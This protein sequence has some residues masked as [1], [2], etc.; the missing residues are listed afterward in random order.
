MRK[1]LA[2][3]MAVGVCLSIAALISCSVAVIPGSGGGGAVAFTIAGRTFV[4][5]FAEIG[6]IQVV[7]GETETVTTGRGSVFSRAPSDTP[8]SATMQLSSDNVGTFRRATAKTIV[9]SQALPL[10]GTATIRF[11]VAPGS[12]T[13]PCGEGVPLAE[14]D[15]AFTAG[16]T[17]VLDEIFELSDA[18]L[19]II[20]TNDVAF[21]IQ[22]TADFDGD[23]IIGDIEISF[24]GGDG[25]GGTGDAGT[26]EFNPWNVDTAENIHIL[27]PGEG[28]DASNRLTPGAN[29]VVTV[30]NLEIGDTVT[31][32]AGRNGTVLDTTTCPAVSGTNY[33]AVATW[34]GETIM[35]TASSDDGDGGT[36]PPG[37][38]L[39]VPID[40]P[41]GVAVAV[42]AGDVYNGIDYAIVGVLGA[43][44]PDAPTSADP[45]TVA[46]D[47]ASLG[48]A[49][50]ETMYMAVHSAWVPDLGNGVTLATLSCDYAEG[51]APTTMAFTLGSTTAEWSYLRPEHVS[52]LGGVAHDSVTVL[53][54]FSTTIGSASEYLGWVYDQSLSMDSSRTLTS[55]TLTAAS[56]GTFPSR[57]LAAEPTWAGTAIVGLTLVGPAGAPSG[58][59]GDDECVDTTDCGAGEICSN[60]TCVTDDECV[61]AADCGPGEICSNG[62]CVTDDGGGVG[63]TTQVTFD[64]GNELDSQWD[65]ASETI[66]FQTDRAPAGTSI[67]NIGAVQADGTGEGNIA[68]GPNSGFGV[69]GPMS[70]VGSTGLLMVNERV[71]FHEYM[72]FDTSQALFT[73]TV[74]DGDDEAFTR[75]LLIPGGGGGDF[76]T[77]SRD[78]STVLW[79]YS[80]RGGAGTALL[81]TAPFSTLAG[82][83]ADAA[84][85]LLFEDAD[86][87]VHT[88]KNGAAL[89][90]DA[91]QVVISLPSGDGFDLF[92]YD[93]SSPP[94]FVRQLT[95]TGASAG[96]NNGVP[97]VSPDATQVAFARTVPGEDT[98]LYLV[99]LSGTG[100]T[101]LT[102]TDRSESEPSWSPGGDRI[103]F[104]RADDDGWN[105][106]VLTLGD[107]EPV[108]ECTSDANCA[109]GETCV[110]G[111]CVPVT[112]G[113]TSSLE[114]DP[115]EKCVDGDCVPVTPECTSSLDCEPDETCVDGTC[116]PGGDEDGFTPATI[117][118]G[119][120]EHLILGPEADPNLSLQTPEGY[121]PGPFGTKSFALSGDGTKVWVA[122]YDQ[123]P[124]VEGD[125]QTQLWSVNT[126]GTGGVR[127]SLPAEDLRSGMHVTTNIDGSV[128]VA[129]NPQTTT[130]YRATPGTGVS[131]L[132]N[133][134]GI[135]DARGAMRISD[136]ASQLIYVNFSLSNIAVAD[137]SGG[138]PTPQVV[139]T[140]ASLVTNGLGGSATIFELDITSSA[141]QWMVGTRTFDSDVNRNRWP[142]FIGNGLSGPTISMVTTER[143]DLAFSRFNMTDDGQTIA[144]CRATEHNGLIGRC[145]IQSIG[146]AARTEIVDEV[147]N[148]GNLSL[149]DDGSKAYMSTGVGHGGGQGFIYGV[150]TG[151]R[152]TGGSQWFADSASPDFT[153][154]EWSDDGRLLMAAVT[155][156]IYVLHDGSVPA[157]FP[158]IDRILYR[159][160]DEDCSMTVRVEVNAP[161]G[162]ERIFTLPFYQGLAASRGVIPGAENPLFRDRS[163]GG[164]NKSTI[165]T[166]TETG[167]WERQIFLT[168]DVGDCASSLLSSDFSIRIVLV[169]DTTTRTVF[170]DFSPVPGGGGGPDCSSNGICNAECGDTDPDCAV[171]IADGVCTAGC[172][173]IDPDCAEVCVADGFCNAN[174]SDLDPDP[175]CSS[176][177]T[178]EPKCTVSSSFGSGDEGWLILGDAQGGRG[179][180]NIV[181]SGG[182][183]GGY[184]SADDDAQ[185]GVWF[186][187]APVAYRGNFSGALGKTLTF[188]LKQSS[189][190]SQFDWLDVSLTG[191]GLTIVVDAGSN[192]GL[193]WTAYSIVL[194]TSAGWTLNALGGTAATQADILT[195]FTNLSDMRSRGEYVDGVD[196]GGLDNVVLNSD[197]AGG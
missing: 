66:A 31:I 30:S 93:V 90:P 36:V 139:T 6:R 175:D 164:V 79:R 131:E 151:E 156:G 189:L 122:L 188:D 168:N 14:Y 157:G 35:C 45:S 134:S 13:D 89:T 27:M 186:F 106:Y 88:L 50:V 180:P 148:L 169:E 133:Y 177:P 25:G 130:F 150:A 80:T 34:D 69:G 135:G 136:D 114:C 193:D 155:R 63:D 44:T 103:A 173:G 46:I 115:D 81:K 99:G 124:N 28:F 195:V 174:C 146:S 192:P 101:Q 17:A 128:V 137:I 53:Y 54:D 167:V 144:Y 47:L 64:S 118:R 84:G 18:A 108:E 166:E 62:T 72:T 21:C 43:N 178:E 85:S 8:S 29:R 165:F 120:A 154:V 116:V 1:R 97:D 170:Q 126:D 110:G 109:S 123:F 67:R 58:G 70:W 52:L 48:L 55:C 187:Q 95:S 87:V 77:V 191:G 176:E 59:G 141:N 113:C 112:P 163:G 11:L 143:D 129:D 15:V 127:S 149:S 107:V 33:E 121:A 26:G 125:P 185:G 159:M 140:T 92:L 145:Y 158:T 49:S 32:R 117:L 162:I 182:N 60:G 23:F 74:S 161:L 197:C 22:I 5:S 57:P 4:L 78:G 94:V 142:I 196:T 184:I 82:E 7:A 41:G 76:I 71:V 91:S 147:E 42:P 100:L 9:R 2:Q 183:P 65:P 75:E 37:T 61:D 73:R 12:S 86:E 3:M 190:S 119:G 98:D 56:P 19:A 68:I 172:L 152:Y 38:S 20:L 132:Y 16:I 138:T 40:S 96:A 83:D 171:C 104:Q 10:S 24:G 194:D 105:I 102:F 160:N 153:A 39:Q 51:G 181:A 111:V 179:D